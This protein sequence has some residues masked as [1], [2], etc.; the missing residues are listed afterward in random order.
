MTAELIYK[1]TSP[2]AIEWWHATQDALEA[3]RIKRNAL[4]DQLSKEFGTGE[5]SPHRDLWINTG[6]DGDIF[7][8]GMAPINDERN[9]PPEGWRFDRNK[10][11]LVPALRTNRG[12]QLAREF[13]SIR[14][15][16]WR[17]D[18]LAVLGVPRHIESPT[19]DEQGRR[20]LYDAGFEFD[21][22]SQTLYQAW[23]SG[24]VEKAVLAAQANVPDVVWEEV[25]RSE[26]YARQEA[27]DSLDTPRKG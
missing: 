2:K 15:A 6:W 21:E 5:H 19:S 8:T 18:S 4:A 11:H 22:E 7:I 24:T 20:R 9:L 10:G 12:K 1:T 3:D 16:K 13:E 26:W 25:K 14:G 23:G 17:A 27:K